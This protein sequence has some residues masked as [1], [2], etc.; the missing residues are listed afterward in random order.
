MTSMTVISSMP[1]P[2]NRPLAARPASKAPPCE[3]PLYALHAGQ[4][5]LAMPFDALRAHY[6]AA[7]QAGLSQR[8][9]LASAR[10]ERAIDSL[11]TLVLGPLARR[12]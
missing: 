11:E 5:L 3:V 9:L 1:W 10:V 4:T 6:A 12:N 8:S 2:A 7:V